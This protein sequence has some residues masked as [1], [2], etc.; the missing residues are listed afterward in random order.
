MYYILEEQFFDRNSDKNCGNPDSPPSF[1]EYK[2]HVQPVW[3]LTQIMYRCGVTILLT[4]IEIRGCMCG[5]GTQV[6]KAEPFLFDSQL[7][8]ENVGQNT[9]ACRKSTLKDE[10]SV[11]LRFCAAHLLAESRG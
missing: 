6:R 3:L 8:Q 1:T 7:Q 11:N 2:L 10:E 5:S 9:T 4:K